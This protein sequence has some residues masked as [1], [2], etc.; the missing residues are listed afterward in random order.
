M[1]REVD[2][3]EQEVTGFSSDFVAVAA[4]E[5]RFDLVGLF[6]NLAQNGAWIVPVEAD[7]GCL[8]LQFE[9]AR[10]RWLPGFDSRQ[11]RLMR[12]LA[13]WPARGAL[14]LFLRLDPLPR[15]LDV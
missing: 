13:R 5:R 12:S 9:R 4:I 3:R 11:K 1:P 10:Q 8:A 15:A 2:D 7:R 14:G 6:T